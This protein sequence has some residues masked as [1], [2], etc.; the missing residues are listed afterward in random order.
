MLADAVEA[1]SRTLKDPSPSRIKNIVEH[2]IDERFKSGELDDSPL[3]LKDLSKIS[4]SF[5]KI[6]SGI[7]HGRIEYPEPQGKPGETKTEKYKES[8]SKSL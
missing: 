6:L 5:Q 2:L 7:F 4:E 1:A 3:T 8:A